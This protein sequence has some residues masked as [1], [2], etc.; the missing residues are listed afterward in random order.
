M[1][2]TYTGEPD[3]L[4]ERERQVAEATEVTM[5]G[6][7]Q[8]IEELRASLKSV[9]EAKD[10]IFRNGEAWEARALAAE[11]SLSLCR[12][13]RDDYLSNIHGIKDR[14]SAIET[15]YAA[16]REELA[17]ATVLLRDAKGVLGSVV[18]LDDEDEGP[19]GESLTCRNII[20]DIERFL[21]EQYQRARAALRASRAPGAGE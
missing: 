11:Q 12:A 20:I 17:R 19:N 6:L 7:W 1:T 15:N 14:I 5:R 9:R 2:S 8:D 4:V 13:E 21:R 10:T 3:E 18:A 16:C